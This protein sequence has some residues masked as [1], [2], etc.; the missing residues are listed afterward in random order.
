MNRVKHHLTDSGMCSIYGVEDE[1]TFHALVN[2][3]KARALLLALRELWNIP[4]KEFFKCPGS[5]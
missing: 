5:K 1:D 2:Y 3:S 4:D